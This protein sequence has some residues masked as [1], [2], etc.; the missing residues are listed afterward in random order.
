MPV[1]TI[2]WVGGRPGH[3]AM[4]EQT[5]LPTEHV[6]LEVRT[7]EE[8]VDAIYR[9]A[10]RGAPAIG[11]AAGFG[12]MLGVQHLGDVSPEEA[13]GQTREVAATLAKA[14]P[15]AVNLFWA[16]D[17]M[18]QRA[19]RERVAGAG[20][21]QIVAAL[22]DEGQAI[23]REDREICERLGE[24]GAELIRD[25]STLLTHCN[26]GWLATVE[27]GTA[28]APMY[29][30]V[31]QGKRIAVFPDE[32]RPLLQGARLTAWELMEAGI[33]VTLITDNMAGRVMFEGRVDAV[34]E[35][36]VDAS[37]PQE[38]PFL[39]RADPDQLGIEGYRHRHG[40]DARGPG[41]RHGNR[42]G[43]ATEPELVA[44][45][46]QHDLGA[47]GRRRGSGRRRIRSVRSAA[48]ASS[49]AL[50]Q[51]SL[52]TSW[53]VSTRASRNATVRPCPMTGSLQPA[54][55]PTKTT[56]ST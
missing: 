1:E 52:P 34:F 3:V 8:M 49:C 4:V 16:L 22:F 15:T 2:R 48:Y 27:V 33:D 11:V 56:R 25:G 51:L 24:V 44:R 6:R 42:V 30:A 40:R 26:A 7:V 17:R 47:R 35:G 20:G 10:V 12:V 31:R 28:L 18:V 14:R 19:E 36:H 9:L 50:L 37:L 39:D 5:L 53:S 38:T 23:W 29:A 54:A 13:L 45:R 32:T 43:S 41:D 55:S 21:A 46:R